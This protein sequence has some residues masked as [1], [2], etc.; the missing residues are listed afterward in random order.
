LL[1]ARAIKWRVRF[2]SLKAVFHDSFGEFFHLLGKFMHKV[3]L[4]YWASSAVFRV[5]TAIIYI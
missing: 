2:Q 5:L 3:I 1:A 4:P